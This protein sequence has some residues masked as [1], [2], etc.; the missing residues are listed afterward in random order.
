[1]L[2]AP[3]TANTLSKVAH[4]I[5]DNAVTAL[6]A[7]ALGR[8]VPLVAVPAMHDALYRNPAFQ[9]SLR[10][11]SELG[12]FI[13]EPRW[14]E[15][16]AKMPPV[17]EIADA[18]SSLLRRRG[19]FR[20]VRFLITAGPTREPLDAVR[21]LTNPSSGK[22]GF[23]LAE[24]AWRRGGEVTL[25]KG[26]VS[27]ERPL[28]RGIK[29]VDAVTT[30]E[31]Y[32]AVEGELKGRGYD[33]IILAA[34]PLDY[35]F[36]TTYSYKIPSGSPA[37]EARLEAKPKI[38]M[39]V[40]RLAPRAVFIGFK[41]EHGVSDE[42]LVERAYARLLEAGMD[43]IVANDLARQGCGFE[44]DTNEVFIVD[45]DRRVVH[46]PLSSKREVAKAILDLAAKKLT[47]GGRS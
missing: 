23:A 4:G 18:V 25:V 31:M 28:P 33:V 42:E 45:R 20:G 36:S 8:G 37:I 40:R 12:V 1:V 30:Q 44:V 27:P 24:E 21:F 10:K 5:S 9:D 34:A 46:V 19:E 26:P 47:G 16:K 22:M 41:A 38:S 32:D 35:G 6:A 13:V 11:L 29:V 14:E 3:A 39:A 15:G 17:E 2:I 43:L 7:A